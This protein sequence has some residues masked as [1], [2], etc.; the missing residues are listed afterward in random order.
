MWLSDG[1]KP[2]KNLG[3]LNKIPVVGVDATNRQ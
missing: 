3:D 2:N 1:E